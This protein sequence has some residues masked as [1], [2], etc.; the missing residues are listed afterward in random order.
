MIWPLLNCLTIRFPIGGQSSKD[1]TVSYWDNF[2][3]FLA[4]V[5]L[6]F[7][8]KAHAESKNP[9][10]TTPLP[11]SES[12]SA[13]KKIESLKTQI[14]K[15]PKNLKLVIELAQE[16]YNIGDYEKTTLLLWKQIESLDHD[17]LILL[18]KAHDKRGDTE[19]VIKVA[20]II[21]VKFPKD[22][23][24]FTYEGLANFS[25]I[26][27]S[28]SSELKKQKQKLAV[29]SFKKAIEANSKYQPAYEAI[30]KIYDNPKKPNYYELRLLYQD[31]IDNIGGRAEF[32]AKLCKV[33][34]LDGLNESA[35]DACNKSIQLNS[36]LPESSVYL[37]RVHRQ[38]GNTEKG[39][40]ILKDTITKFP[41]S[42][43]AL[44]NY[45]KFLEDDK[46]YIEAYKHY[47]LC[48]AADPDNENC[49]AGAA[50]AGAQIQKHEKSLQF[51]AAVCKKNRKHSVLA[52]T[53]A[54]QARAA[55]ATE[56]IR[57]YEVEAEKC[58]GH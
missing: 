10:T 14:R 17:S 31:M 40:K 4:C 46:N 9:P 44:E 22:A 47:D 23:E 5:L 24:A 12:I 49:L 54:S 18:L 25:K 51:L 16:F 3:R 21:T 34:A 37:G 56:W 2:S 26:K 38:L 57:A 41:K 48:A 29:D 6:S 13:N 15:T 8:F 36:E 1:E 27:I 35:I 55:K 33:N 53:L 28:D 45:A 32:Y 39:M 52:R 50:M 42:A 43:F 11:S 20:Q 7:S 30:E 19:L 58:A